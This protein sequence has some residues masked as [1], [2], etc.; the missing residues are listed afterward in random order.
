MTTT[1]PSPITAAP[2]QQPHR[3]RFMRRLQHTARAARAVVGAW[4]ARPHSTVG[5]ELARR[6]ERL[7][8]NPVSHRVHIVP[9]Q[10]V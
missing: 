5:Q 6:G 10:E 8:W 9:R 4:I 2:A 1:T 7:S 3:D